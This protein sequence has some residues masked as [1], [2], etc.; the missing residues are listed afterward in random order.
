MVMGA[1]GYLNHLS[2]A[3]FTLRAVS[4]LC[5]SMYFSKTYVQC[6]L[7]FYDCYCVR[8]FVREHVNLLL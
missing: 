1:F 6:I 8:A 4:F 5:T 7:V 2:K 3:M